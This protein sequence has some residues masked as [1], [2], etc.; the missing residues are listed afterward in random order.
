MCLALSSVFEAREESPCTVTHA[1][2]MGG[3]Q[4]HRMVT[5]IDYKL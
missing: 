4:K 3:A 1:C 2:V 5:Q